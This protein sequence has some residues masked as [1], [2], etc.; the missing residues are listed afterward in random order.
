MGQLADIL[1]HN[2]VV[3]TVNPDFEII[4]NGAVA[5]KDG[6][7][8]FVGSDGTGNPAGARQVIDAC[9]GIVMPGLVNTHTH[10]PMSLFRGLADDLAL[11]KWLTGHIFPAE[12]AHIHPETVHAATLLSCAEMLLS[13]TTAC[14]DGYFYENFVAEAVAQ[15]GIRAVLGQGVIDFP[16]PDC[17]DPAKNIDTALGFVDQWKDKNAGITPS[18]FCHSPYTCSEQ[19]LQRAK[20]A[21][22]KAG[23]IFQIHVAETRTEA[24][25]ANI[26]QSR[27]VA[28]YLADL[29]VLGPNTLA[30]H[31]VW[32]SPEDIAIFQ[33]TG[34]KVSHNPESNM[35]LASGIAPVPAMLAVGICAGLGTDGCASNN[36]LDMFE[37]MGF[38]AKLHKAAAMDPMVMDAQTVVRM[39]TI[40]GAESL[41]L[42]HLI[43]SVEPGK[44]AD[45]IVIDT[46]RPHLCPLYHPESHL[47]YA[48]RGAD[49]S[50]VLVDGRFL[51]ENQRLLHMDVGAVMAEVNRI[52]QRVA[53]TDKHQP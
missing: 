36:N 47:V 24:E 29:G 23:V 17:P 27:S 2:A 45:L 44:A 51:V 49:V 20:Q 37:T 34:T 14:C 4:E 48:V 13:G 28:A 52:C 25:N 46:R 42:D 31:C 35:K 21:A 11:D 9:G 18:I 26:G 6:R 16:A 50:H 53:Q 39:A 3:V 43:G 30:S 12:A 15:A 38:A 8:E 5:I 22:D 7:I 32:L 40:Q 10:L 33:D 41:G 19:T 1:I